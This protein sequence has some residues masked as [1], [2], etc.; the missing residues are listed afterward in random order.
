V[1]ALYERRDS[2]RRTGIRLKKWWVYR[3]EPATST[4]FLT[5]KRGIFA[6]RG[7]LLRKNSLVKGNNLD[8]IGYTVSVSKYFLRGHNID[9]DPDQFLDQQPVCELLLRAL[10]DAHDEGGLTLQAVCEETGEGAA[11]VR[12]CLAEMMGAQNHLVTLSGDRWKVVQGGTVNC[13]KGKAVSTELKAIGTRAAGA[14]VASAPYGGPKGTGV[15]KN[16]RGL[17]I[18]SPRPSSGRDASGVSASSNAVPSD[19]AVAPGVVISPSS[20]SGAGGGSSPSS[21]IWI[22]IGSV[23]AAVGI[24]AAAW[25]ARRV[26]LRARTTR[27]AAS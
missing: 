3:F 25:F 12:E 14:P 18:A 4:V 23:I 13:G 7:Q 9:V 11:T 24:A 26:R 15:P 1:H 17:P 22:A 27:S 5:V 10:C 6:S 8:S 21:S 20:A 2:Q 16:S 19:S